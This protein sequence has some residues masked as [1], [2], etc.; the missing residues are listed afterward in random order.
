M[1]IDMPWLKGKNGMKEFAFIDVTPIMLAALVT[2]LKQN[3]QVNPQGPGIYVIDSHS[4][5]AIA[6][7]DGNGTLVVT[8]SH[9]PI[10][11]MWGAIESGIAAA[12]GTLAD[13]ELAKSTLVSSKTTTVE[14]TPGM[15]RRTTVTTGEKA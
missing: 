7:Y 4:I 6:K 2:E 15:P 13:E 3:G 1:Y 10:W 9:K 8:V 14:N 12:L 5:K 11:L